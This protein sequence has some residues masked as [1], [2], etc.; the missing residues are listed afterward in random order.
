MAVGAP[1]TRSQWENKGKF[2]TTG[3]LFDT[4]SDQIKPESFG[5]LKEISTI[6]NEDPKT[7]VKITG[8]TDSDG[9][10]NTN[11]TLSKKRAAAVKDALVSVFGISADKFETDGKGEKEP[12]AKGDTPEVKAANRRVVFEK[13]LP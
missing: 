2:V 6:F 8:H 7:K 12:G 4:G 13:L 9:D 1:D 11:L 3:I 5:V 10:D